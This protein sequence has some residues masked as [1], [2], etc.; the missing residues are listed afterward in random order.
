[1]MGGDCDTDDNNLFAGVGIFVVKLNA[2]LAQLQKANKVMRRQIVTLQIT[3]A[4]SWVLADAF[5]EV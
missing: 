3:A 5:A 1:M 4:E 2:V